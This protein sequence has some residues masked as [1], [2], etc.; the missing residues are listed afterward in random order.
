ML[1]LV[2]VVFE[3]SRGWILE[4]VCREV[5]RYFSGTWGFHHSK[6]DLPNAKAYFYAHYTFLP[7]CLRHNPGLAER[8]NVVFFTHP[9]TDF[10]ISQEEIYGGLRQATS[11]VCLCSSGAEFLKGQGVDPERLVVL[12]GGAD[13]EIFKP[14]PKR[15]TGT[16]GFSTAYYERKNPELMLALVRALSEKQFVLLGRGWKESPFSETL[17][18]CSNLKYIETDYENYPEYYREM[19]VFLSTSQ[20]ESG[21]VPLI[22]AMMTNVVPVASRTGFAPDIIQH[23]ENGYLFDTDA[24]IEDVIPLVHQALESRRNIRETVLHCSWKNFS[25]AVQKLL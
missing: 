1:D 24:S 17:L 2:F 13:P 3:K 16:I 10:K 5:A 20:V 15:G 22:E 7:T 21:P 4:G 25:T 18:K 8:N 19:D 11:I 9:R 6:N 14:G 23:G 12:P